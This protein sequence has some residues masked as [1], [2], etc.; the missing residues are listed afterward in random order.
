M[1]EGKVFIIDDDPSLLQLYSKALENA[2]FQVSST[3]QVI[4]TVNRINEFSPDVILL[5]VMMPAVQGDKIVKILKQS[6]RSQPMVVLLSNKGEDEL[7]QLQQECGADDYIT[8]MSGPFS[9][10]RKVNEYI[11]REKGRA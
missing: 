8:K 7:R 4:G 11:F 1:S 10:I 2:G 6:V 5:D 9:V 3:T